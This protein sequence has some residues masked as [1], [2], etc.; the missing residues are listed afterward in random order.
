MINIF[1]NNYNISHHLNQINSSQI[2]R[3]GQNSPFTIKRISI[4]ANI[5]PHTY[6][7]IEEIKWGN[8]NKMAIAIGLNPSY[9]L[10]NNLDK[11]NELLSKCLKSKG[12]DGYYLMNLYSYVQTNKFRRRGKTDQSQEIMISIVDFVSKKSLSSIDIVIFCGSSCYLSNNI[13]NNLN[14]IATRISS[15][16]GNHVVNYYLTGTRIVRHKHPSRCSN[17][18]IYLNAVGNIIPFSG[19]YIK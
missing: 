7:Y 18:N 12:Y 11:T 2:L 5:S 3:G 9:C 16:N 1:I 6:K 19:H 4:Q 15:L 8:K 13:I 10:P 17:Q 14:S